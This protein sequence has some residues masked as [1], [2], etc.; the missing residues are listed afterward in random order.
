MRYLPVNCASYV[1]DFALCEPT[2]CGQSARAALRAF[3]VLFGL[4]FSEDPKKSLSMALCRV[5]L[6]VESDFSLFQSQRV[7]LCHVGASRVRLCRFAVLP[8]CG[9]LGG[10]PTG[11]GVSRVTRMRVRSTN[12]TD[13]RGFM[14]TS[15]CIG[16]PV[17]ALSSVTGG[18]GHSR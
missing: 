7:I 16:P 15:A 6:G 2:F 3:A 4:P 11:T 5:F 1:D 10:D 14:S 9:R 18:P 8:P 12:S 13:F 17:L